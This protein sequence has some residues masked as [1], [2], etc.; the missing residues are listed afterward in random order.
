ML[1]S[2]F[3]SI[4]DHDF[5]ILFFNKP[6]HRQAR[7]YL[8][9]CQRRDTLGQRRMNEDFKDYDP[10]VFKITC[11]AI[12]IHL[13]NFICFT[14]KLTCVILVRNEMQA[15]T[16]VDRPDSLYHNSIFL[17][18]DAMRRGGVLAVGRCPSER[19]S[20]RHTRVLYPN[21]Q[22]RLL[23]IYDGANAPCKK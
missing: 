3:R 22:G 16:Y 21:G 4:T 7:R 20:V 9:V 11:Y 1:R 13:N 14:V 18:S 10:R 6:Y 19:L 17:P 8:A 12:K 2:Q 23:H 15:F 5:L